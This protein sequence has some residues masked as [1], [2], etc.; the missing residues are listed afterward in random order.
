[1][2]EAPVAP[3]A[4]ILKSGSAFATH[5]R[6]A[7]PLADEAS[8]D[9][10]KNEVAACVKEREFRI[11]LELVAT[12]TMT[13]KM[14]EFLL[15]LNDALRARGGWLQ[16]AKI[17][18]VCADAFRLTGVADSIALVDVEKA[19]LPETR[20]E[21]QRLG[22]ILVARGL[23][24]EEQVA[25]ALELQ[26]QNGKKLGEI[27]TAKKWVSDLD[28]LSALSGQ[29][30]IP[31][32]ELRA[33]VFDPELSALLD[34]K[35]GRRLVAIP[36]FKVRGELTVATPNAQNVPV[37]REIEE[38]TDCKV[39]AVFAP[40][41]RVL[42]FVEQSDETAELGLELLNDEA[43]D[44]ELVE[45]QEDYGAIDEIATG[46]PVVNLTNSLIQRAIREGASDVHIES[47][48]DK[49]RV[50]FRIDGVLYEVMTVRAELMPALISRLKVMA[51]LDISERRLPQDGRMQVVTGG[52]SVDLRFSS[53]PALFGE[54][55]VLR[56]LDKN[57]ALLEIDQLGMHDAVRDQYVGLL[58]RGYGLI[59][60]T[61]PTGSGKNDQPLRGAEPTEFSRAEHHHD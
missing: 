11:V 32:V 61:G 33:G 49:G 5:L 34:R 23:I 12:K 6:P 60:V 25:E 3:S 1:M 51:N 40:R 57:Q 53:M 55:V 10:L 56:I 27:F 8:F 39:R 18:A 22:D 21:K 50:R 26:K 16:I 13:S 36:L 24:K 47:F 42:E 48:R 14:L 58:S 45:V 17:N 15:D 52:R 19:P 31:Q 30:S 43:D 7:F 54:K 38:L 28:V 41:D 9:Q 37:L 4:P 46:S 2:A 29:L 59:L 20:M 44:L 35:N